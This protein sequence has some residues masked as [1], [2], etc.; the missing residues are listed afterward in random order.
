MARKVYTI[1]QRLKS[2]SGQHVNWNTADSDKQFRF[3]NRTY[4]VAA[5]I[6]G[7]QTKPRAGVNMTNDVI[8]MESSPGVNSG[9]TGTG[10]VCFKAEPNIGSTAGALSGDV[11]GYECSLGKPS[12]AGTITGT[13]SCLKCINNTNATITGGVYCLHVVT[14]GDT[15]AWDGLALLPDDSQIAKTNEDKTAG[16]KGWVKVKI[17]ST[18]YYLNAATG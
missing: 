17:G 13:A 11:R 12:G 18:V 10:I 2:L 5:S 14:H 8:G 4:T 9:F 16:T 7:L 1:M 15:K 3:N 6:I